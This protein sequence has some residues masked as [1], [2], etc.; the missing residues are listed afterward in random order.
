MAHLITLK[1]F[2]DAR[3]SLTVLEQGLDVGFEIKRFY[4]IY[5][6]DGK[7]VRAGH[8]HR[9]NMQALICVIGSCIVQ[10]NDGFKSDTFKLDRST[11][12]L[13]MNPE[14][15]HKIYDFTSNAILMVLASEHYDV[16]DYIDE[17]Y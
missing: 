13:L 9:K 6:V 4:Y 17:E 1:T 16:N 12:C 15:W 3:G 11:K 8:R 5:N 7:S 10:V 14:D 2:T